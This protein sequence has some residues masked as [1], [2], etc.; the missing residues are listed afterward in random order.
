MKELQRLVSF[1]CHNDIFGSGGSKKTPE[2]HEMAFDK[3]HGPSHCT[4]PSQE[5][6]HITHSDQLLKGIAVFEPLFR[7]EQDLQT[8]DEVLVM[9]EICACLTTTRIIVSDKKADQGINKCVIASKG[10]SNVANVTGRNI[11]DNGKL[12]ERNGKKALGLLE[13]SECRQCCLDGKTPSGAVYE[14]FCLWIRQAMYKELCG[15][16]DEDDNDDSD[17]E[18][19]KNS[20]DDIED[21]NND[22]ESGMPSNCCFPGHLAFVL[23]GPI[24]PPGFD[25]ECKAHC[26]FSNDDGLSKEKKKDGRAAIRKEQEDEESKARNCASASEGRGLTNREHLLA[27]SIAQQSSFAQLFQAS[28]AKESRIFFLNERVRQAEADISLWMPHCKPCM[29]DN[30]E[31]HKSH[32]AFSRLVAAIEKKGKVELELEVAMSID[33]DK[34]Q[35][36]NKCQSFVDSA[37]DSHMIPPSAKKAKRSSDSAASFSVT[38]VNVPVANQGDTEG[39]TP[40]PQSVNNNQSRPEDS[41]ENAEN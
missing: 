21:N 2:L 7:I 32:F 24:V 28:C 27:A 19:E 16:N 40:S 41:N 10:L 12:V 22:E 35:T 1:R 39:D 14:D 4:Q 20:S 33:N 23:W 11:W 31:E 5:E 26:F 8:G 3:H 9:K 13:H 30:P 18:E 37:L 36:P 6:D 15:K 34:D 38:S 25:E 17:N 29:F